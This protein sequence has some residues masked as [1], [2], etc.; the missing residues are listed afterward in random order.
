MPRPSIQSQ[1]FAQSVSII[2]HLFLFFYITNLL[3]AVFVIARHLPAAEECL[4]TKTLQNYMRKV[5]EQIQ[6]AS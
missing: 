2:L 4:T 5:Q 3:F 1:Y 6:V